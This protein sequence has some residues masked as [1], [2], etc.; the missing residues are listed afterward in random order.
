MIVDVEATPTRIS[1][2]VDAVETMLDRVEDRF[3]LKP[4]RITADVAYGT[5]VVLGK[6]VAREIA[7]HI[8]VWNQSEIA[9]EGRFS[10]A[11]F[12]LIKRGELN[13]RT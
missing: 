5:G 12:F 1:M 4:E 3:A 11:D 6:I 7:P 9:T 2:E 10:R 13:W 8:P